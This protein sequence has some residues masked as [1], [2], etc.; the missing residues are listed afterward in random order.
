MLELFDAVWL[1]QHNTDML[2]TLIQSTL[3][4]T[5]SL[6][7][8]NRLSQSKKS[9]PFSIWKSNNRQQNIVKK[10]RNCSLD[11]FSPLF[12]NIFNISLTSRVNLHIHLLNVVVRF[13]FSIWYVEVRISRSISESPFDVELTRVDCII[14]LLWDGNTEDKCTRLTDQSSHFYCFCIVPFNYLII[15]LL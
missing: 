6:F 9:S 14:V 5:T 10:R 7:S 12:H 15:G 4:I 11:A 8:K 2:I 1:L 13:I 3:V